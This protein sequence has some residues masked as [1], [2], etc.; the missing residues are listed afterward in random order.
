MTADELE[1]VVADLPKIIRKRRGD[2]SI[3]KAAAECGLT[4]SN[5]HALEHGTPNPSA[6]VVAKILRWAG[7]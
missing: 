3:R 4:F 5:L 2:M 1:R 6:L 7:K